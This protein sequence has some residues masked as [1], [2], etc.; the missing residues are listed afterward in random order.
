MDT[1]S[2]NTIVTVISILVSIFCLAYS[3]KQAKQQRDIR[4]KLK[5]G[6]I[7]LNYSNSLS[8]SIVS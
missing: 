4:Q 7:Y 2:I 5:I 6:C 3:S 8:V 1:T